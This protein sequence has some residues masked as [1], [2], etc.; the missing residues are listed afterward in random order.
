MLADLH[1]HTTY[2]DGIYSPEELL[3]LLQEREVK[4]AAFTDHNALDLNK[5]QAINEEARERGICLVPNCVEVSSEWKGHRVHILGYGLRKINSFL[6]NYFEHYTRDK[7]Q[8]TRERCS[9]S[10]QHPLKLKTSESVSVS[11]EDLEERLIRKNAFYWTDLATVLANKVN[12]LLG[13]E[14][15]S[16]QDGVGLLNG[17]KGLFTDLSDALT[18]NF[19]E[20]SA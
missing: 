2:S 1:L 11:F 19:A 12:D 10:L 20:F 18:H 16:R 17:K 8:Q 15:M 9:Q 3:T 4:I 13:D 6:N 7:T 5:S 14:I